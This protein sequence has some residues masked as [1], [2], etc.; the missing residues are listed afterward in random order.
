MRFRC[1][2]KHRVLHYTPE[3]AT[4]IINA[5]VVLHNLCI[6]YNIPDPVNEE[7]D[8]LD[9]GVYNPANIRVNVNRVNPALEAGKRQRDSLI[10]VLQQ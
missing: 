6:D 3:R 2:L 7:E 10:A 9:F 4:K 8:L 1:L 5:C